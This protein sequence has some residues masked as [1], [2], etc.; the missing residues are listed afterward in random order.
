MRLGPYRL[1][2]RLAM[3][4]MA[5]IFLARREAEAGFA[6]EL[7]VKRVLPNLAL[8]PE[9]RRMFQAE[10]RLAALLSHPNIVQVY[11]YGSVVEPDGE[12]TLF[13]A[14]ELVRGVDL[15]A[16]IVRAAEDARQ[17]GRSG[18]LAPHHAARIVALVCE[19]LAHA[20]ALTIDGKP[21][22]LV[23]RDV[24]PSNV[25]VSFEGA[26][27]LADFGIAKSVVDDHATAHGVV[28]G[29][30]SYLSP[31]QARGEP[32]DRRSDVFN[33]GIVLFESILGE[34]LFFSEPSAEIGKALA[35]RGEI[36]DRLRLRRLPG[37]LADVA[38]RALCA[39]AVDRYPDALAMREDLEG[40]VRKSGEPTGALEIGRLVRALFP[41]TIVEDQRAPRAAG[42][43]AQADV[44]RVTRTPDAASSS[45]SEDDERGLIPSG[46]IWLGKEA[47]DATRPLTPAVVTISSP[48]E[49]PLT[50]LSQTR[51]HVPKSSPEP[52]LS[53]GPPRRRI[54]P[55]ITAAL[56]ALLVL[57]SLVAMSSWRSASA[58]IPLRVTTQPA[59]A[60][61]RLDGE[62]RGQTPLALEIPPRSA[63][64][65][66]EIALPGYE[67]VVDDVVLAEPSVEVRLSFAL[68]PTP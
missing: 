65:H 47:L 39:R 24:T 45:T 21:A 17:S 13:L 55:K 1:V 30:R 60:W 10:A 26:V 54:D 49:V 36:P 20:H 8:A 58:T 4:G 38:E 29:K 31:E 32:L 50:R 2:R 42:T 40:F 19:A 7:V 6:R 61:V 35:A 66:V 68:R 12:S 51:V 57:A 46:T 37:V 59:A 56:V 9:F 22:G 27:K 28:K 16:L 64:H 44:P 3:G 18:A 5:E 48:I 53:S 25:L 62:L 14:M 23:H 33:V 63:A 67:P 15:R 52:P 11:D 43:I 34:S 41:E